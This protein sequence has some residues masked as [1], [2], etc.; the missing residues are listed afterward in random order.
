MAS[1]DFSIMATEAYADEQWSATTLIPL[2]KDGEVL[3]L[4]GPSGCGKT[5]NFRRLVGLRKSLDG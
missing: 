1:V 2:I 3:V 5:M 4:V